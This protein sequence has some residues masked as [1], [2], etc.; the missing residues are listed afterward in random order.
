VKNVWSCTA[1]IW[2]VGTT[3]TKMWQCVGIEDIRNSKP[4]VAANHILL[5]YCANVV[6]QSNNCAVDKCSEDIRHAVL[7]C[8]LSLDFVIFCWQFITTVWAGIPAADVSQLS[9][10]TNCWTIHPTGVVWAVK[11]LFASDMSWK[12][13]TI[14]NLAWRNKN[15][16]HDLSRLKLQILRS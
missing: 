12:N 8:S 16:G 5:R 1:L 4:G 13:D 11:I 14:N 3:W 10:W 9:K 15:D 7:G 2:W 6:L